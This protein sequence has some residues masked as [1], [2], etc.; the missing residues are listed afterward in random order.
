MGNLQS[1]KEKTKTKTYNNGD[2]NTNK[3]SFQQAVNQEAEANVK[4]DPDLNTNMG[5]KNG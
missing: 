2:N 3:M 4:V 5:K 1:G